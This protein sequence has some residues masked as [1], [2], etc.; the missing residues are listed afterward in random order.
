MHLY[1]IPTVHSLLYF[2]FPFIYVFILSL[3]S[4]THFS[5]LLVVIYRLLDAKVVLA[6]NTANTSPLLTI[7]FSRPSEIK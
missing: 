6:G 3:F 5:S 7:N 1:N 2:T 4:A